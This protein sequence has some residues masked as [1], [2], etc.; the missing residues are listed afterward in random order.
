M[1]KEF[2]T[3]AAGILSYLA[4]SSMKFSFNGTFQSKITIKYLSENPF[5]LKILLGMSSVVVIMEKEFQYTCIT[6][7]GSI[8]KRSIFFFLIL[9]LL[10]GWWALWCR[11]YLKD[12]TIEVPIIV[13]AHTASDSMVIYFPFF[14]HLQIVHVGRREDVVEGLDEV[15]EQ[16]DVD[17]LDVS[18]LGQTLTDTDEHGG[19]HQH[20]CH[21]QRD[22]CLEK[23]FLE[24]I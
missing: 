7:W 19:Q 5:A 11:S 23:E 9:P 12:F 24:V 8:P 2:C 1:A 17:H 3:F 18:G 15:E 4:S 16:P 22:H 20:H 6:N 10:Q 13:N 21:V 14:V